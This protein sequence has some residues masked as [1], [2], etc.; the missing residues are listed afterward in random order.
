MEQETIHARLRASPVRRVLACVTVAGLG[1]LFVWVAV[2]QPQPLVWRLL[3][4]G[5]GG[6]AV[7]LALALYR[8][9]SAGLIL[10]D[11]ALVDTDGRT[12][13]GLEDVQ[14]VEQGTFAFKPSN[15]FVLR[16]HRPARA[17]WAP[18]LWWRVSSR[19]GVGGVT[20]PAAAKAMADRITAL[21]ALRDGPL[22]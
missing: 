12:L 7:A 8:A 4:V 13:A 3:L 15:G 2:S 16:L 10:T 21:L 6:A 20:P 1:L 14:S 9:T 18:G 5:L 19:V 17:R 22:S 11:S